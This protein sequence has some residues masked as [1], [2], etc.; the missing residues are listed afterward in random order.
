MRDTAPRPSE[1]PRS[2]MAPRG[3]PPLAREAL[4][5]GPEPSWGRSSRPGPR[6][7]P[8]EASPADAETPTA[9]STKVLPGPHVAGASGPA[10]S[11]AG[12]TAQR[13]APTPQPVQLAACCP[14][15][16]GTWQVPG[17]PATG[18]KGAV[19][20]P[21][22][23]P[24]TRPSVRP[25]SGRSSAWSSNPHPSRSGEQIPRWIPWTWE[26]V[27]WPQAQAPGQRGPPGPTDLRALRLGQRREPRA[28]PPLLSGGSCLA[29]GRCP[30]ERLQDGQ[31]S[32]PSA[33]P[34]WPHPCARPDA[35]RSPTEPPRRVGPGP[36]VDG[37][38]APTGPKC[39]MGS[40]T[41]SMVGARGSAHAGELACRGTRHGAGWRGAAGHSG[42]RQAVWAWP[43]GCAAT[44][45][46]AE[47]AVGHVGCL[48]ACAPSPSPLVLS[49]RCIQ[50]QNSAH[51][52]PL[53]TIRQRPGR[54]R[55]AHWCAGPHHGGCPGRAGAA[56][57]PPEALGATSLH[58]GAP[59]G[60]CGPPRPREARPSHPGGDRWCG[61]PG[62]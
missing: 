45:P 4:L 54:P 36:R 49:T 7:T 1:K 50:Q 47:D 53:M 16:P 24:G 26:Q 23:L 13:G 3:C 8:C 27:W 60:Y 58:P 19:P 39:C 52:F 41:Y 22:P 6:D 38:G 5:Q 9:F 32:C 20:R 42:G 21:V 25:A 37:K 51:P 61:G 57:R 43:R 29:S 46:G 15:A 18:A 62:A 11:L 28:R 17:A 33:R 44:G 31:A 10:A 56:P 48:V 30:P 12:R 14:P 35:D 2:G 55:L 40:L 34:T 59:G